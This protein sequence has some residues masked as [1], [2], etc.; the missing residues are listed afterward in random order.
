VHETAHTTS[1]APR[2]FA[3]GLRVRASHA[4]RVEHVTALVAVGASR[5]GGLT[6]SVVEDIQRGTGLSFFWLWEP[7]TILG[8]PVR[9]GMAGFALGTTA[10]RLERAEDACQERRAEAASQTATSAQSTRSGAGR[11]GLVELHRSALG[12]SAER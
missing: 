8:A 9:D 1:S 11:I 7:R 4:V 10:A 6:A 3:L 12:A 5:F 2:G